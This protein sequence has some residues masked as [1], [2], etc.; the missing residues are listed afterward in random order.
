MPRSSAARG[1]LLDSYAYIFGT[2]RYVIF[3]KAEAFNMA[4]LRINGNY[5]VE[6]FR[7]GEKTI[8]LN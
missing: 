3:K 5:I 6:V 8:G 2:G 4:G 1:N 7:A